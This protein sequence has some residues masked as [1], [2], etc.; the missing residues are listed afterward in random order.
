MVSVLK[1][2]PSKNGEQTPH[3]YATTHTLQEGQPAA[4][5]NPFQAKYTYA[6]T[7][8]HMSCLRLATALTL[9]S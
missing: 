5:T 7:D 2:L 1:T 6:S 4:A 3:M 9:M 8:R